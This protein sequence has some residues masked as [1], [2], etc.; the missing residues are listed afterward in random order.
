VD[1]R[2]GLDDLKR[3]FLTLLGLELQP[4]SC[5]ATLPRLLK[6]L[7]SRKMKITLLQNVS[8]LEAHKV[9]DACI[10]H[11]TLMSGPV[12]LGSAESY[13]KTGHDHKN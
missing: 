11:R 3:K 5:P 4:L 12:L 1:P 10:N 9:W 13:F 8:N 7:I 6:S 2:A